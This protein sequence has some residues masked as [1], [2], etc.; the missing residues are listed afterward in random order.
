MHCGTLRL[1]H[2]WSIELVATTKK[3]LQHPTDDKGH[4]LFGGHHFYLTSMY[5]PH[6]HILIIFMLPHEYNCT[7][8]A[9]C[10]VQPLKQVAIN[11][12]QENSN[13]KINVIGELRCIYVKPTCD[14][15]KYHL[16]HMSR[17]C[18][19]SPSML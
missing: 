19:Y 6:V 17:L 8:N 14:L 3:Q 18:M 11:L 2:T 13:Y 1:G 15:L 5:T 7:Y 12:Q 9:L 16:L 4:I 10:G